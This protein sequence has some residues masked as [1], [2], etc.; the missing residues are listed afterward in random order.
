MWNTSLH[1]DVFTAK[2]NNC[3]S[4]YFAEEI[5]V[6]ISVFR[7]YAKCDKKYQGIT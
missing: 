4:M 7:M 3:L 2:L 1:A 6:Y 5:G